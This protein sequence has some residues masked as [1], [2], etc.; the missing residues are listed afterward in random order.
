MIQIN[1]PMPES[2]IKCPCYDHTMYGRCKAKDIWFG[3]EDES[4]NS[5]ERPNWCPFREVP[6]EMPT[7]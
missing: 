2:C 4:W 3:V 5:N 6:D 1:I 7:M